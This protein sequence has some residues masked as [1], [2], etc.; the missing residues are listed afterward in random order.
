MGVCIGGKP[1]SFVF[2]LL[3]FGCSLAKVGRGIFRERK[4]C[5]I[6]TYVVFSKPILI[7]SM[8]EQSLAANNIAK[9]LQ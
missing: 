9:T 5:V 6:A 1:E 7:Y 4:V 2:G 3:C 8:L